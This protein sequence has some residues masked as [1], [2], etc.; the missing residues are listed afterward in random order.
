[1]GRPCNEP[2]ASAPSQLSGRYRAQIGR[3]R[4]EVT[5]PTLLL[6]LVSN[7]SETPAR[8][9]TAIDHA[10]TIYRPAL[11]TRRPR[12]ASDRADREIFDS[13]RVTDWGKNR[14]RNI[15]T[16]RIPPE[17]HSAFTRPCQAQRVRMIVRF[18]VILRTRR[19]ILRTNLKSVCAGRMTSTNGQRRGE[20][21][22]QIPRFVASPIRTARSPFRRS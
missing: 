3:R 7:R 10:A 14:V 9:A 19:C 2:I 17:G 21:R 18:Q 11:R 22:M 13:V 8:G 1:M 5:T 15:Y 12:P 6:D 16:C 20:H 4:D